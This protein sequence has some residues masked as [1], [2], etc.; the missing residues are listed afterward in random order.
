MALAIK[1]TIETCERGASEFE[2]QVQGSFSTAVT[3]GDMPSTGGV[4]KSVTVI[5]ILNSGG[6][7]ATRVEC[8][9]KTIAL[10]RAGATMSS[11]KTA[12]DLLN[13]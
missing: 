4:R 3:L 2:P 6:S 13:P 11:I 10:C 1:V 5:P 9:N 8:L 7:T 12:L